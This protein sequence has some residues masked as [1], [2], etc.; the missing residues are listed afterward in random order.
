MCLRGKASGH[1]SELSHVHSAG[2]PSQTHRR[3]QVVV[4]R[5]I[6]LPYGASRS[7]HIRSVLASWTR[8][9]PARKGCESR[10]GPVL[11]V[12]IRARRDRAAPCRKGAP[13]L[14]RSQTVVVNESGRR[15]HAVVLSRRQLDG[16]E[17]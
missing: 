2:F 9:T 10:R 5:H 3:S 17:C 6:G 13:M 15:F 16:R 8:R 14:K 7:L 1:S 12:E 11:R 4:C